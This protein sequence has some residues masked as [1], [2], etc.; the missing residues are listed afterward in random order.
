MSPEKKKTLKILKIRMRKAVYKIRRYLFGL[1]VMGAVASSPATLSGQ[2]RAEGNGGGKEKINVA[3]RRSALAQRKRDVSL[4]AYNRM[5]EIDVDGEI[6]GRAEWF[7]NEFLEATSKHLKALKKATQNGQK[8]K[9]V[10]NNF[11][12]IVY[13]DGRLSGRNNY[14]I[15]AINRALIDANV[16]GDL[17]NVLP[18]YDSEGFNAVECRRFVSHLKQKGFGDCIRSG[19][20]NV[21]ELEIGD[22]VMTPRGGGR[23]HATTYIGNGKVRSFN[24]DGEWNLQKRTGIVIKTREITEKAIKLELERQQLITPEKKRP[25]DYSPAQSA[26]DDADFIQRPRSA[27]PYGSDAVAKNGR[28]A[29]GGHSGRQHR[30]PPFQRG[31]GNLKRRQNTARPGRNFRYTKKAPFPTGL[32]GIYRLPFRKRSWRAG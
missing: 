1:S 30:R 29:A 12:D 11:F 22:I 20:I 31:T 8:T 16:C 6:A 17:N 19:S 3:E 9:Y 13:P 25:P 15:T 28:P 5:I 7:V 32:F 26:E 2:V 27:Q 18:E 14:C 23:Y 21:R 10:K 24:N 4:L